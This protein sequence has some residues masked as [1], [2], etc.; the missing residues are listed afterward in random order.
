MSV[1]ALRFA[2]HVLCTRDDVP[3]LHNPT[4][5]AE[6]ERHAVTLIRR[7]RDTL[8]MTE[9]RFVHVTENGIRLVCLPV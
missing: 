3:G 8:P 1:S 6:R 9:R 7:I 4:D 5:P 2:L